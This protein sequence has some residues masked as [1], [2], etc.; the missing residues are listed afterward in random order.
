MALGMLGHSRLLGF[1][2]LFLTPAK[3]EWALMLL[4]TVLGLNVA[5]GGLQQKDWLLFPFL[6]LQTLT[7]SLKDDTGL[8]FLFSFSPKKN[9]CFTLYL[10]LVPLTSGEAFWLAGCCS[11][12][13]PVGRE[14]FLQAQRC[15]AEP[16][17]RGWRRWCLL[18]G[19]PRGSTT[20]PYH[21]LS[22]N[23]SVAEAVTELG[24]TKAFLWCAE[25]PIE[26]LGARSHSTFSFPG[27]AGWQRAQGSSWFPIPP[28]KRQKLSSPWQCLGGCQRREKSSADIV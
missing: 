17:E 15:G 25:C 19:A 28:G 22:R 3:G 4:L 21:P 7:L 1:G 14:M 16:Q 23:V 9:V 2:F 10:K 13:V 8:I 12:H 6:D 24:Q 18:A 11:K 5:E 20:K 26:D 27:R